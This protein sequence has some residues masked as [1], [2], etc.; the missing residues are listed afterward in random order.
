VTRAVRFAQE[1]GKQPT[2]PDETR[3]ILG[4]KLLKA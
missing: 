4:L 3:K 2:T 1:L